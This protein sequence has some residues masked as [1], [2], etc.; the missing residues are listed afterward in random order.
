M[1]MDSPQTNRARSFAGLKF[2]SAGLSFHLKGMYNNN[3]FHVISGG[4]CECVGDVKY[5]PL[6]N[7]RPRR[8]PPKIVHLRMTVAQSNIRKVL[9]LKI[10][11]DN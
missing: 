10:F 11:L 9:N 5:R 4:P 2:A 8:R 3:S 6:G 7:S 1:Y